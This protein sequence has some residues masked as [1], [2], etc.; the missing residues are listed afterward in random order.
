MAAMLAQEQRRE[1]E[2][3]LAK[4]SSTTAGSKKEP[5]RPPFSVFFEKYLID[6]QNQKNGMQSIHASFGGLLR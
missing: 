6:I 3:A 2:Q 4:A 1:E 5:P